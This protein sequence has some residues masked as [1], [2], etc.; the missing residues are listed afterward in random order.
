[1]PER[2]IASIV[3][4]K[5]HCFTRTR[6]GA[7][8]KKIRRYSSG[9][10][11]GRRSGRLLSSRLPGSVPS[12]PRSFHLR[13]AG[14]LQ[15]LGLECRGRLC[16]GNLRRF[17]RR[18]FGFRRCSLLSFGRSLAQESVLSQLPRLAPLLHDFFVDGR[19]G[20][21]LIYSLLLRVS[22]RRNAILERRILEG[23]HNLSLESGGAWRR[24][25]YWGSA[26]VSSR[27][28]GQ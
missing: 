2:C 1:V 25:A 27:L 17:G 16:F 28:S 24:A 3:V 23:G 6:D 4:R 10:A 9:V 22:G 18:L 19:L 12:V 5:D 21:E 11:A 20:L 7:G 26:A 13:C 15:P 8:A 14:R